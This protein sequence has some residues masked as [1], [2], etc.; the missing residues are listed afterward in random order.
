M[1]AASTAF[2]KILKRGSKGGNSHEGHEEHE[3]HGAQHQGHEGQ[4]HEGHKVQQTSTASKDRT[5]APAVE[6]ETVR[7]EHQQREQKVVEKERH[8][9]HFKTTVQP[10]K[11]REVKPEHHVHEQAAVQTEHHDHDRNAKHVV[12]NQQSKFKD[13]RREA[14]TATKVTQ[15]PT[16]TSE[17]V[18][19][20]YHETVQPVIEKET[21]VPSITHKT[22]PVK[23]VHQDPSVDEGIS[24]K[25]PVS[26]EEFERRLKK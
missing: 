2:N 26:R 14:D 1:D 12:N 23:E 15:E 16:L 18:H 10:L 11:E 4:G 3:G 13:E 19:H 7:R 8:Q 25:P 24:T 21:V 9:D 22:I 5:A 6:H 20:H 17:H